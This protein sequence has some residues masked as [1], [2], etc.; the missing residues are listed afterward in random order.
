MA[1]ILKHT[2]ALLILLLPGITFGE[3]I[4]LRD[5]TVLHGEITAQTADHVQL[6]TTLL[7]LL[8]IPRAAIKPVSPA[9]ATAV[10]QSSP[11]QKKAATKDNW[12]FEISAG[13]T[14]KSA[15]REYNRVYGSFA[16]QQKTARKSLKTYMRGNY[17]QR[18][19]DAVNNELVGGVDLYTRFCGRNSVYMRNELETDAIEQLTLRSTA[20]VGLGYFLFDAKPRSLEA[21]LGSLWRFEEYED[22]QSSAEPGVDMGLFYT[23]RWSNQGKLASSVRYTPLLEGDNHLQLELENRLDMPVSASGSL[24][25]RLELRNLYSDIAKEMQTTYNTLLVYSF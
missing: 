20:S 3:A 10:V 16:A 22:G 17:A 5:G 2:T 25:L 14:G 13:V 23:Q 6:K 15:Q 1:S 12:R 4:Q 8:D 21:R 11:L 9:N 7:G 18:D 19:E 24:K